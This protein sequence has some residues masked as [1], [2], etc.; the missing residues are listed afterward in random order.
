MGVV[1]G[2]LLTLLGAGCVAV[3]LSA[4]GVPGVGLLV[5]I[6]LALVFTGGLWVGES[7]GGWRIRKVARDPDSLPFTARHFI[8]AG[9]VP[10]E[11]RAAP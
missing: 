6:S 3:G 2:V 4:A 1:L 8:D 9:W 11:K 5:F 7:I 10:P